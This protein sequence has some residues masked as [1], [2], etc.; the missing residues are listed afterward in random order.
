MPPD[1]IRSRDSVVPRQAIGIP[2]ALIGGVFLAL[3]AQFQHRGVNKVEAKTEEVTGGLNVRQLTLLLA[4]PA[5]CSE[6]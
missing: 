2:L 4:R 5:G 3:G 1:L 6:R